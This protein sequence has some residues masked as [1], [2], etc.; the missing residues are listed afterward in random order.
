MRHDI[1]LAGYAFGLR[2]VKIAD[3]GEIVEL[4]THPRNARYINTTSV[5]VA[6]Q[7]AWIARYFDRPG[8]WY[9]VLERL[10]D[11]RTE[12]VVGIYGLDSAVM[13]AEWGRWVLRAGSLAAVECAT[14]VYRASFEVVGLS[15]VYCRTVADNQQVVSFHDSC[16]APRTGYLKGSVTIGDVVHDQVEHRITLQT[17]QGMAARML[18]LSELVG[19]RLNKAPG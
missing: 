4:R 15:A 19:R 3:A 14:L 2:P 16:G 7:E 6:D 8:D 13:T 11:G 1:R 17:W 5:R 12:G 18:E 9:F 10:S